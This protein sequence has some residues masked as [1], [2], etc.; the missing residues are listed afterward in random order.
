MRLQQ[1]FA[2]GEMGFRVRLHSSNREA[3]MSALCH[4]PTYA[5]QQK[6]LWFDHLV[7]ESKQLSRF[8]QSEAFF[9]S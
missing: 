2:V 3:R 8:I 9:P 1:G 5:V 6:P 4:K 7:G